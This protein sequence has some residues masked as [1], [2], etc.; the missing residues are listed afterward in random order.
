MLVL[1]LALGMALSAGSAGVSASSFAVAQDI[2]TAAEENPAMP[3]GPQEGD[4]EE[5]TVFFTSDLH[6]AFWNVNFATVNPATGQHDAVTGLPRV[7]KA[8]KNKQ[9]ALQ[10]EGKKWLTLDV[11]DTIEGKGTSAFIG[12]NGFVNPMVKGFNYLGYN[13][14]IPGNHEFNYGVQNLSDAYMGNGPNN[15]GFNGAKLCGN[16][17][18]FKGDPDDWPP[19]DSVIDGS[20]ELLKGFK[21]YEVFDLNG[22]RVA[23]IGMSAPGSDTWD[24]I[25]LKTANVY[26]ESAIGAATRA[27]REIK[28]APGGPLADVIVLAAH[29]S[30]GNTF[31]RPGSGA[32]SVLGNAY[33]AQNVDAFLGAHGHS[34]TNSTINGVR[35]GENSAD[36]TSYGEVKIKATYNSGKWAVASKTGDVSVTINVLSTASEQ[37]QGYLDE[38]L[39]EYDYNEAAISAPIGR[40]INGPMVNSALKGTG[41]FSAAYIEPTKM[42]EF[43]HDVQKYFANAEISVACPFSPQM[44]HLEGPISRGSLGGI[45][46]YD[47]NTVYRL[48]MKGWQV[49]KFM[50]MV[51]QNYYNRPSTAQLLTDLSP[52]HAT[53]YN[54]DNLGGVKYTVDLTKANGDRVSITEVKRL[55]G[56]WQ[57]YDPNETY[58]VVANDYRTSS[59]ILTTNVFTQAELDGTSAPAGNTAFAPSILEIDCTRGHETAPDIISL[60]AYYV[61]LRGGVID[62]GDY[63]KNWSIV[64]WWE[65]TVENG[66][67]L[68][69]EGERL[70][71]EG[72][73]TNVTSGSALKAAD[74]LAALERERMIRVT[75]PE[76][77]MSSDT[78]AKYT[79]SAQKLST[80]VNT[81]TLKFRVED[82]VFSG[83]DQYTLG[84][85]RVLADSGWAAD[86]D[87]AWTREVTLFNGIGG[88][89]SLVSGSFDFYEAVFNYKGANEAGF[90]QVEIVSATAAGPGGLAKFYIGDPAVT[91]LVNRSRYDVNGDGVV[92][93]ADV[94]AAAY[95]FMSKNTDTGWNIELEFDLVKVA[96]SYCDVNGDGKVDIEDLIAI[97]A[98][99]T[100]A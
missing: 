4:T 22:V 6:G 12:N 48:Q 19:A 56:Q 9:A 70:T 77:L 61:G 34:R 97:L 95:F 26:T 69:A 30:T 27:I 18:N 52:T 15:G 63:E 92:D 32:N 5:I 78:K 40:L 31:N 68:R 67:Y 10:A 96:P 1:A 82:A 37:D 24:A 83:N 20:D 45:Y 44:Q 35:Y 25:K 59:R 11:G 60:M 73:I 41:N 53:S 13:A 85:W 64:P 81:I 88:Q 7:A 87:D 2:T 49:K 47:S 75:G 33:I 57:A 58:I 21:A 84:N 28:D 36:G 14:L 65:T 98:N 46:R 23:V 43:I 8:L 39:P 86:G 71:Q 80:G 99:F 62:S 76:A 91:R 17:F 29:M 74:V 50:E 42:V 51:V 3:E 89:D 66:A 72:K 16:V 55:N 100:A 38:L 94:A 93:L 90:T 54:T 79:F